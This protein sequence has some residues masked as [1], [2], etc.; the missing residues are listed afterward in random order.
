MYKAVSPGAINV[1]LPILDAIALAGRCGFEGIEVDPQ[2]ALAVGLDGVRDALQAAKLQNAG[3]GLPVAFRDRGT[4]YDESLKQFPRLVEAA[5]K[6]GADRCSTYIL[7]W[8]DELSFEENYD[9]HV[10][11]LTPCA[12]I[13]KDHG[14][15]LGLEFVGPQS[16]YRGKRHPFLHTLPDML[17]LAEDIGTGNVGLLLD[18]YHWFTA[19]HGDQVLREL[20]D[21]DIVLVH[22]NDALSGLRL[23]ELPDTHRCLPGETGVLPLR[24]FMD[25]LRTIQYTGPVVVEPFSDT[26][27][28][29]NSDRER[30]ETTLASMD[31]VWGGK[32]K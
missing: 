19:G 23:R 26:L 5:A 2:A 17:M 31:D 15:R 21:A 13:L 7:P 12:R 9:L 1:S 16:L 4:A 20:T 28:G 30:F 6:L 32:Q 18:A 29:L 3:F 14:M 27:A 8:H 24:T 10:E 11:T 25:A 22:I